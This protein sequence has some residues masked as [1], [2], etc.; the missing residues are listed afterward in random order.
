[1]SLCDLIS[2]RGVP[3]GTS[4]LAGQE[5]NWLFG[6]SIDRYRRRGGHAIYGE[7]DVV[8]RFNSL[9]YRCP[10]FDVDADIRVVAIGCSHVLGLGLPQ[11]AIFHELFAERLRA[12][13]GKS[14]VLWNLGRCGAS[15]DYISR[16][17]YLAVPLLDP[18]IVLINFTH[19]ARREYVSVQNHPVT[20]NPRFTP[21]DAVASD[22]FR[23]FA[24]LSSQFDDQLNF[25][26]NYKAMEQ[27]LSGRLWLYSRRVGKEFDALAA[28][29]M[30]VHMDLRRFAGR[31]P[32]VDR[33]RDGGHPGPESHRQLAD[34]YWAKFVE[35]CPMLNS[36]RG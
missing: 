15:N 16:L 25:F 33:G 4:S 14:V 27:L 7:N 6:D 17:L 28:E 20:Y 5:V 2:A 21:T 13:S 29:V 11:E 34:L 31:L 9:G 32:L 3:P 10:E 23:H 30:A 1:M 19:M 18:H 35:F 22:I 12:T 26:K 24:A 36:S 8:Y